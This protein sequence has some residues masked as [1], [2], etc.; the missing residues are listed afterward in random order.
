[1]KSLRNFVVIGF[2]ALAPSLVVS[3]A[4]AQSTNNNLEPKRQLQGAADLVGFDMT[5][6]KI[7]NPDVPSLAGAKANKLAPEFLMPNG[8]HVWIIFK[9][10][11]Q[12]QHAKDLCLALYVAGQTNPI[13]KTYPTN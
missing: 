2:L 12:E 11:V 9:P 3:S 10:P 7:V 4:H 1:M 8:N 6:L 5:D 13:T